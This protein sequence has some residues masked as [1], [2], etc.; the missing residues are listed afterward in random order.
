MKHLHHS[1][2]LVKNKF[3]FFHALVYQLL[4]VMSGTEMISCRPHNKDFD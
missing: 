3:V 2:A 1:G 4:Q